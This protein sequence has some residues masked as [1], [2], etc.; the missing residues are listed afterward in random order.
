MIHASIVMGYETQERTYDGYLEPRLRITRR[1]ATEENEEEIRI[2]FGRPDDRGIDKPRT[3]TLRLSREI[4]E[5]IAKTISEI[6][7]TEARSIT[8]DFD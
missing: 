7:E 3:L 5:A 6:D 1:L 4:A 2:R 8:F